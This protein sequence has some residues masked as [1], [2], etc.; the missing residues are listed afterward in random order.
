MSLPFPEPKA[1][2]GKVILLGKSLP[3]TTIPTFPPLTRLLPVH[4]QGCR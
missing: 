2:S 3:R 1:K 4:S